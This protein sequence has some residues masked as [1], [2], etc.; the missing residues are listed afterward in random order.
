M[1]ISCGY[2]PNIIHPTRITDYTSTIIDNIYSNKFEDNSIGG[3]ILV[4]FADHLSQ[5]LSV[6][7]KIERF[8]TIDVFKRDCANF[9]DN[10]FLEDLASQDWS[11]DNSNNKHFDNFLT[12]FE[13]CVDKHAPMKKLNK[14]KLKSYQNLGLTTIF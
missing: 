2:L 6:D 1:M 14:N 7:T 10:N 9:D 5:F 13:N 8:K 12:T 3:N 4:Q 11:T